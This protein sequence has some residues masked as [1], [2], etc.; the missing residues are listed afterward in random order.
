MFDD[1]SSEFSSSGR[2]TADCSLPGAPTYSGAAVDSV[3]AGTFEV[4]F[5][6]KIRAS[7]Y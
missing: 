7:P 3:V 4:G 1:F 6:Q 2:R 5:W